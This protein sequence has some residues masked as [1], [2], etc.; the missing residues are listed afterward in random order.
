A[1]GGALASGAVPQASARPGPEQNRLVEARGEWFYVDGEPFLV[2]GIGYS[3]YR[4]GQVP[5][6]TL[7]DLALIERDFQLIREAGFNT[8]RTWSP[9]PDDV[10]ALAKRHELMVLQG[11]WIAR[12]ADYD[13]ATFREAMFEIL[14]N[15][16]RR[17]A[18]HDNILALI[19]GNELLPEQVFR[20]GIAQ[21]EALL[22]RAAQVVK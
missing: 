4:P 11:I 12:D 18:A 14:R 9:L 5:W 17:A 22:R 15:E 2:K 19:V 8:I 13:S 1:L 10:L 7:P 20:T 16:A 3:P 21:T 6:K